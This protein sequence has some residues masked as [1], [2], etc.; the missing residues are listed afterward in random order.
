MKKY[1]FMIIGAVVAGILG[2][3]AY[4]YIKQK[5]EEKLAKVPGAGATDNVS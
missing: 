4:M 5:K 1:D 2:G 3:C